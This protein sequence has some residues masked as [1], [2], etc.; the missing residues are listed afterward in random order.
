MSEARAAAPAPGRRAG[1]AA[2]TED[3]PMVE[4]NCVS[5]ALRQVARLP[6]AGRCAW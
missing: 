4:P 5:V 6:A 3:E 2:R 1:P